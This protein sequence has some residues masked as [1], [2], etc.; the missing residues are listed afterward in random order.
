MVLEDARVIH[1]TAHA[2]ARQ[3]RDGVAYLNIIARRL[4]PPDDATRKVFLAWMQ[5]RM[6]MRGTAMVV[7]PTGF[8]GAA[9]RSVFTGLVMLAQPVEPMK[10]VASVDEAAAW[11]VPMVR[12]VTEAR[13]RSA[14][15]WMRARMAE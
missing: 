3:H 12:G 2:L 9:A 13:V 14:D 7:E 6:N 11:I 5:E 15:A 1:E 10:V 8:A 4:P